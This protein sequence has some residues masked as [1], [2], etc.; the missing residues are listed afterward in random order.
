MFVGPVDAL[1]LLQL[2]R[3]AWLQQFTDPLA[4]EAT[5][6]STRP[7]LFARL[8]TLLTTLS[9]STPNN[10]G[11]IP[12]PLPHL[13]AALYVRDDNKFMAGAI[14]ASYPF[15][16][17][18]ILPA[19][20]L[21]EELALKAHGWVE[22]GVHVPDFFKPYR[23]EF[24]GAH[25]DAPAPLRFRGRNHPVPPEHR[26][27]VEDTVADYLR[28][29]AVLK[30]GAPAL[31][32][33]PIGM[34]LSSSGKPRLI[35][36]ARYLNLWTPSP[37]M[38][39]EG[40]RGFQ[41]GIAAGD[42]LMSVDMKSGYH[43]IRVSP[44]SRKYLGFSWNGNNYAFCV[45]PFGWAPACYVFNTI[46]TAFAAFIR[47]MGV[48]CIVYLDDFGFVLRRAWTAQNREHFVAAMCLAFHLAGYYVSR[49][50]SCLVP[51]TRLQLLGFGIDTVP[52]QYFVPQRKL[53]AI[54]A[55]ITMVV[56]A[57]AVNA[58]AL[59]SLCGKVQALA[60]AVPPAPIFLRSTYDA[61]AHAPIDGGID[62]PDVT[63]TDA[64]KKDLRGLFA[65]REWEGL[66]RWKEEK[67]VKLYTDACDVSWGAV[68]PLDGGSTHRAH[69]VF[70]RHL[71]H[72]HINVKEFLAVSYTL[73]RL[74][75]FIP[76]P[77]YL[78][79]YVDNTSVQYAALRGSSPDDLARSLS[80]VLLTWQLQFNVTIR[81]HRVASADNIADAES[82]LPNG[83]VSQQR[84]CGWPC[85]YWC[86][87]TIS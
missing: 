82:R 73:K 40:L 33:L 25:M 63:V 17:D 27:F 34:A 59:M 8:V 19:A 39:Y 12:T 31:V 1:T 3:C 52:Q 4:A 11:D 57:R 74:G 24:A 21:P 55:L 79:L 18:Y 61:L 32:S 47:R 65:L 16:R 36:D 37:D 9:L 78:D 60:L 49:T 77:C 23:G 66:S 43:H 86:V 48:H 26:G 15:W 14:H 44:E 81:L 68:L 6:A 53:D 51:A 71:M 85:R 64:M 22:R 41:R 56:Q 58:R 10:G 72:L 42:Y 38:A 29:G 28:S 67:H 75:S 54:F 13:D 50:K 80:R 69:G 76:K 30:L 20:A 84:P 83:E 2:E 62:E 5:D 35:L 46:S 70:P 45:L 87:A 7:T